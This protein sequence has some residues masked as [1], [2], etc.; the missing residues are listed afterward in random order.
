M[1]QHCT[2]VSTCLKSQ[3]VCNAGGMQTNSKAAASAHA[4]VNARSLA[5]VSTDPLPDSSD[6]IAVRAALLHA[7]L[8]NSTI[9][10]MFKFYPSYRNWDVASKLHHSL[11]LWLQE[12]GPEGLDAQLL[13]FP[14]MLTRTPQEMRDLRLWFLSLGLD[15]DKALRRTPMLATYRLQSLQA[16]L[17]AFHAYNLPGL[18]SFVLRHPQALE[19]SPDIVY[20][21]Y[22][23]LAE[24]LD[25]D[26][27]STDAAD[28]L[29]PG[30][31]QRMFN[32]IT[33]ADI[34]NRM[35]FLRQCFAASHA[36]VRQ[37]LKYCVFLLEPRTME[38]RAQFLKKMLDLSNA[39]LNKLLKVPH[40]LN[41]TS[42]H[43]QAHLESF[44]GLGF[45]Q[46]HMKAMC[47]TR[48][49]LLLLDMTSTVNVEKW[50][51]LTAILKMS[52][53]GLTARPSVLTF[54][55]ANK[56]GPRHAFI[57]QLLTSGAMCQ[58]NYHAVHP[59]IY[60]SQTDA[61]FAELTAKRLKT[62][63]GEYTVTFKQQWQERWEF[64]RQQVDIAIADIGAHQSVLIASVEDVLKPRLAVLRSLA[65]Q[66]AEFCLVDHL[67]AAATMSNAEFAAAYGL[68]S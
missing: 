9:S 55:L 56:L 62:D 53:S 20:E 14:Y 36:T 28:L 30:R 23:A 46:A 50:S 45:S 43:L 8:P 29:N 32:G 18:V 34:K 66:Q 25:V 3:F 68:R 57:V 19:R 59:L 42:D 31:S 11:K 24:L 58:H 38:D 2:P 26:P 40:L 37:A 52:V 41:Y 65:A 5:A 27:A 61:G 63:P 49:H 48:P 10:K 12:L 13:R 1:F 17:N 16:K 22:S 51:F 39:E 35:A 54:S 64:L 7:G 6:G 60:G 4:A 47:L 33:A 67:T 21:L 44:Y 15:A